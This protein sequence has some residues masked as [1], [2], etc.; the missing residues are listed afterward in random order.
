MTI[1]I[2]GVCGNLMSGVACLASEKGFDVV[3]YDICFQ[4]PMSTVLHNRNIKLIEGYPK[5]IDLEEGDIVI[6]GNQLRRTD[7]IIQWLIA[8]RIKLY[9]APEWLMD[10]VL[11][12]RQVI[13]VTGSHGKTTITTMIAWI[14]EQC[15][16][17]PGYLIGG[18]ASQLEGSAALGKGPYFVIEADEYDSAF[19]DKRPK[20]VHYWPTMLVI[21]NVE[22]DHADIYADIESIIKQYSYLLRLLPNNGCVVTTNISRRLYDVIDAFQ[23]K[24]VQYG[25]YKGEHQISLLKDVNLKMVGTFNQENALAALLIAKQVGISE[26][27]AK[28]ALASCIGP[29]RRQMV[30]YNQDGII[31]YDDFAH[32]PS[33]LLHI[34]KTFL[35]RGELIVL[36]HP[37]T[38]TQREGLMDK[39]VIDILKQ[40]KLAI[41]LLPKKHKLHLDQY[42]EAGILLCED[43]KSCVGVI[44]DSVKSGDQV[45][46]T[47]ARYLS[48]FWENLIEKLEK[49]RIE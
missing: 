22:Y 11:R 34:V 13:A 39:E 4:P 27:D 2:L 23:L 47:S 45:I 32:H 42:K 35:A 16:Y 21:S 25:S 7:Q 10:F 24:H 17:Q 29:A 43:E 19:F 6:V 44:L 28:A 18:V 49:K 33:E 5:K 40:V 31:A 26:K 3:G 46:M 20:F 1:H 41:I 9:S 12:D 38:Y 36:Y 37:I 14:L 8:E 15:G 48:E 30:M